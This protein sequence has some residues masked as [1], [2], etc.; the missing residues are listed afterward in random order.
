M[1]IYDYL[2]SSCDHRADLLHGINDPGP[3][4]CPSCGAE[5][6][7]RKQF[8]VPAI[9]FKGSG[10][11]KKD[12]GGSSLRHVGAAGSGDSDGAK[13]GDSSAKSASSETSSSSGSPGSSAS[14]ET[15]SSSGSSDS[16]GRSSDKVD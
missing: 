14:S 9:H 3:L 5:G 1:P 12:R 7:M 13:G 6:S 10:W 4:F 16:S 11:A 15:S 8:A 2:C